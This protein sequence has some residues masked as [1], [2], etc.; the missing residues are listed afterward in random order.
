MADKAY[1]GKRIVLGVSGSIAAYKAAD[2]AS[3][4]TQGGAIVQ[5]VMTDSATQFITP[6]TMR[7]LTGRTPLVGV[8]D[9]TTEGE[10]THVSVAENADLLLV[11][12]ATANI[13]AKMAHGLADDMLSTLYLA[14]KCPVVIAPA[15][16]TNM[17]TNAAVVTNVDRLKT[18][19]HRFVDPAE[20]YLA[21]G[22]IGQG[23]LA[24]V[25]EILS[26]VESVFE[27]DKVTD[28]A[29]LRFLI[30][31]GPTREPIDPV[32]YLSNY[33]TGLMGFSI[34]EAAKERGAHVSLVTG[35]SEVAIPHVDDLVR[36]ETAEEML[37]A[38]RARFRQTDVVIMAAA[39]SDFRAPKSE[40][41]LKKSAGRSRTL[42]LHETTD[43]LAE[44]GKNK[45]RQVLVGF[46]LESEDLIENA[47]QKLQAKNLDMVVANSVDE[48]NRP[49]GEG[50]SRVRFLLENGSELPLPLM[51]KP[52]IANHLLSYIKENLLTQE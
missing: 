12:P 46:A 33:S 9:E 26:V 37:E 45:D 42:E 32:R 52:E 20:G 49:F 2:I 44:I 15:M 5:V 34:A 36:V 11:A 16:N 29:G 21:C 23:K 39:V 4:L 48:E 28:L 6:V 1:S 47:R 18:L 31:A 50:P 38:I 22:T 25:D 24:T 43:I 10:V 14:A 40:Q 30:T 19:G 27:G 3:A 7:A 17:W 51:S 35:P 13:I 8:F 41:K